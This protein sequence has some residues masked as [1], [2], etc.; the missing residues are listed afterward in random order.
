MIRQT[1]APRRLLFAAVGLSMAAAFTSACS[2][3]QEA[4]QEPAGDGTPIKVGLVYSQT[5]ALAGYGKQYIEGWKA[6]LAYATKGTGKVGN[7]PVEVKEVDDAGDPA[8][9]VSAAKD[10]IGQG[11]KIIAGSTGSAV[12]GQVAP[13]A[14]QNK[15]QFVSGPAASDAVTGVNKYT[16]AP[17]ASPTRTSSRPSPTCPRPRARRSSCSPRRAPSASPTPTR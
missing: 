13:L 2:S 3:P 14:A 10:L 15:V 5:G 11:Y 16:S 9:A 6:G 1:S 12:A 4:A 8:K 7:R 17:A